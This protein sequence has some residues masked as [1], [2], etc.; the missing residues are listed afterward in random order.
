[1][2]KAFIATATLLTIAFTT[3]NGA[4]AGIF[5]TE[6]ICQD[7]NSVNYDVSSYKDGQTGAWLGA[8]LGKWIFGCK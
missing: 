2:K 7:Y 4:S 1:M 5:D 6:K 3:L 8:L